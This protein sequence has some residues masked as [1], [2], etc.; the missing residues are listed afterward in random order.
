MT[1]SWQLA[2]Q[3]ITY[4]H[5]S[6]YLP[7]KKVVVKQELEIFQMSLHKTSKRKVRFS[8]LIPDISCHTHLNF[9][10]ILII[11]KC[12]FFGGKLEILLGKLADVWNSNKKE[13][14]EDWAWSRNDTGCPGCGFGCLGWESF[15]QTVIYCRCFLYIIFNITI[16]HLKPFSFYQDSENDWIKKYIGIEQS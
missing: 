5:F 7:L 3:W 4:G 8:H 13:P 11:L 10:K 1:L 2:N 16:A 15:P 6:F 9:F 12:C 14:K